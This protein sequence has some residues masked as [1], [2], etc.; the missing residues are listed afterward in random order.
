MDVERDKKIE[1]EMIS[2]EETIINELNCYHAELAGG[3]SALWLLKKKLDSVDFAGGHEL[4]GTILKH[5]QAAEVIVLNVLNYEA[6]IVKCAEDLLKDLVKA[7]TI[8]A[9]K[10]ARVVGILKHFG[11]RLRRIA[12]QLALIRN[13]LYG[14]KIKV[15]SNQIKVNAEGKPMDCTPV[16]SQ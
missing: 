10:Q 6:Q 4:Y 9:R 14:L 13:L 5:L 12:G 8:E 1:S 16:S 11:S 3:L 2:E 15:V 7:N